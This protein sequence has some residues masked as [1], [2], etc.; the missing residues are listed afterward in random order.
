MKS[1]LSQTDLSW[2]AALKQGLADPYKLHQWIWD[3]LPKDEA[4]SRDFLFRADVKNSRLRILLLSERV[5][6]SGDRCEWRTTE[7]SATFLGH[8]AY[9]FQL[10]ANPTFR[11]ASDHRRLALF[12]ETKIREW[13]V[14]KL[15][16]AGCEI[17][18]VG[19]HECE[20]AGEIRHVP[21]LDLKTTAPRK[22]LLRKGGGART[23]TLYSVDA[24]GSLV[25]KDEAAFRAA[26]DAGIGPA[27]G[28]GFGLLLLQP[29]QL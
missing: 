9:R 20:I 11:R 10:R 4:A 21:V 23:G 28:F 18:T 24:Q 6:E 3:A 27:K 29:I 19:D 12:D 13:F 16:D 15:A 5:P 1:F 17:S 22:L 25:V 14:R 7:V 2:A 26:F 8:G